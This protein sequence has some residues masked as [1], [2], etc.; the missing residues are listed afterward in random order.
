MTLTEGNKVNKEKK[1]DV[2]ADIGRE[3]RNQRERI[4]NP[5]NFS[6]T[7]HRKSGAFSMGMNYKGD[8]ANGRKITNTEENQMESDNSLDEMKYGATHEFRGMTE[9]MDKCAERILKK[10]HIQVHS[11]ERLPDEKSS[12]YHVSGSSESLQKASSDFWEEGAPKSYP[13]PTVAKPFKY[14]G[15]EKKYVQEAAEVDVEE[16]TVD[17]GDMLSAILGE[18]EK[19]DDIFNSLIGSRVD[20]VLD[21]MKR[22]I[23]A[24]MFAEPES[25]EVEVTAEDFITA[26]GEAGVELTEE[27]LT[28]LKKSTMYSAYRERLGRGRLHRSLAAS[29]ARHLYHPNENEQVRR[30]RT[31][32][33]KH[34]KKAD[35]T[36]WRIAAKHTTSEDADYLATLGIELTEDQ[37]DIVEVSLWKPERS[38]FTKKGMV[39]KGGLKKKFGEYDRQSVDKITSVKVLDQMMKGGK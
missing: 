21:H 6:Y 39:P 11:V 35:K 19:T 17:S 2:I 8:K 33:A 15:M 20:D 34:F 22:E 27:Q 9:F 10:H 24:D 29:T 30:D 25:E 13:K 1:N 14:Y 5:Y 32:A 28:E 3:R 38:G 18:N 16:T 31:E 12:I 37:K 26:L 4:G 23:A 36:L 7:Q